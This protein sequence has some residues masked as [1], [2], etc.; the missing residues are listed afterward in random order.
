MGVGWPT[1]KEQATITITGWN[2]DEHIY[3]SAGRENTTAGTEGDVVGEVHK[4]SPFEGTGIA[5]RGCHPRVTH[6]GPIRDW[7]VQMANKAH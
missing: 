7:T 2:V 5:R 1:E 6:V 4:G 3:R